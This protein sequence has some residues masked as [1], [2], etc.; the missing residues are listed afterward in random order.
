V[1]S[2]QHTAIG[3]GCLFIEIPRHQHLLFVVGGAMMGFG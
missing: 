1:K 2:N 3:L